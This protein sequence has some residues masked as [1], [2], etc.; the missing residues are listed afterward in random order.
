MDLEEFGDLASIFGVKQRGDLSRDIGYAK[1]HI[2]QKIESSNQKLI[3]IQRQRNEIERQ[4]NA[5]ESRERATRRKSRQ[6]LVTL[7]RGLESLESK[8]DFDHFFQIAFIS[9]HLCRIEESEALESID[10]FAALDNLKH[11]VVT[12]L[13]E[14]NFPD[15]QSIANTAHAHT[16]D[17]K[18]LIGEIEKVLKH[19]RFFD[20]GFESR[21]RDAVQR[22]K[23]AR[24]SARHNELNSFHAQCLVDHRWK[25]SDASTRETAKKT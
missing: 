2:A 1:D 3:E 6:A 24:E 25:R 9:Y 19:K 11:S 12:S 18:D 23:Q 7:K 20:P 16:I 17:I 22:I 5:D 4:R 15:I 14:D 21:Y 8:N 13:D 10:D